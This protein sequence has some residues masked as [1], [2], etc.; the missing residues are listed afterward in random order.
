MAENVVWNKKLLVVSLVVA[1]AAV[2][3]FYVYDSLK[4]ARLTGE[5]VEVL[6]WKR[7]LT[8]GEEI[9]RGDI[10]VTRI[11][12]EVL[13]DIQGV[14]TNAPEDRALVK[15]HTR[16]SRYVNKNDFVRFTDVRGG[17]RSAPSV[18]I[19][20][21]MRAVTVP[22]DPYTAPGQMLSVDDRVDLIGMVSL[23]GKPAKAYLLIENLRVLAVGGQ[24]GEA[25]QR[26]PGG[27]NVQRYRPSRTV[28]RSVT[29]E[30]IPEVA[31]QLANL[32][33]RIQG[34]TWILVR[35]PA[36]TQM[37]YPNPK[38]RD[39]GA[40]NPEVLPVLKQPLPEPGLGA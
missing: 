40:I 11:R 16:V 15:E 21:G 23:K 5:M 29:V 26:A 4:Q 39:H 14:V 32:L 28:Y 30:T 27:G 8:P 35:N 3:L 10:G 36:D 33:P 25:T 34:K 37:L 22:V 9:G 7:D 17:G 1:L 18:K 38:T 2:A 20:K 12:R 19:R 24:P 31:V 13:R 6:V